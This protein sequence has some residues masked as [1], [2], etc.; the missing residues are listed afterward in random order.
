MQVGDLVQHVPSSDLGLIIQA[1]PGE[2]TMVKWLDE[3][4]AIEDVDL[5]AGALEVVSAGR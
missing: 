3:L 4:G 2:Y 1:G 5:Y